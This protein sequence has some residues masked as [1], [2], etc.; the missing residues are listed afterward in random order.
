MGGRYKSCTQ[1]VTVTI[2]NDALLEIKTVVKATGNIASGNSTY[3]MTYTLNMHT[4][5][6][7]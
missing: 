4:V 2:Q 6:T 7:D 1:T 3:E 5:F